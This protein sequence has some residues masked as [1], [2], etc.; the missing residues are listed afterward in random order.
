VQLR[1][2]CPCD[3][4]CSGMTDRAA[5]AR[6]GRPGS[7]STSTA[8]CGLVG[9]LTGRYWKTRA[10]RQREPGVSRQACRLRA[11]APLSKRPG[12]PSRVSVFPRSRYRI[13]TGYTCDKHSAHLS[14]I[15]TQYVDNSGFSRIH[16]TWLAFSPG[17]RPCHGRGQAAESPAFPP[18]THRLS[19]VAHKSSTSC[20]QPAGKQSSC[21][22]GREPAD[23]RA[24]ACVTRQAGQARGSRPGADE[25]V[26]EPGPRMLAAA[27]GLGGGH[28]GFRAYR[29]RVP[30]RPHGDLV[31]N[32]QP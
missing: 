14:S 18:R 13:T 15:A 11:R 28:G 22:T 6:P 7:S 23:Q 8:G 24:G 20:A 17:K 21:R 10:W 4:Q 19:A 12:S 27:L 16:R 26:Q 5:A 3:R 25:I 1:V 2:T 9:R 31:L 29:L 32:S 30:A